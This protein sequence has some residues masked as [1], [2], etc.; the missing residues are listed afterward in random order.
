MPK[1]NETAAPVAAPSTETPAAPEPAKTDAFGVTD[2]QAAEVAK[3]AADK[4]PAGSGDT[5][6]GDKK[7]EPIPDDHPTVVA[8]NKQIEDAKSSMGGNLTKQREIITGLEKKI[9]DLTE[10]KG[11]P[12][13]A[14]AADED[15]L[16]KAEDIK[17]SKD[18]TKEQREE[19]TDREIAQM[20][21][22]ANMKV[23]QNK[24][25]AESRKAT[26]TVETAKVDDVNATVQATARA[27]A[28]GEDGKENLEL[29]NQI[30]ENTKQFNLDGL[31]EA[32][33]KERVANAA[34]LLPNYTPPK[35]QSRT[36]TKTVTPPAA[37]DDPFGV[38]QIVKEA[39]SQKKGDYSL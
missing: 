37:S 26:K 3:P 12:A 7:Y 27:L 38:D 23:A 9:A 13:N 5:G 25:Y 21:E 35:E 20:D 31:D 8:L 14:A 24:I 17:F 1:E 28:T 10:G 11:A 29:A 19:M 34:R 36:T 6:K 15:V 33:V 4:E 16:F 30:I 22:I 18:L 32:A 2:N 39:T